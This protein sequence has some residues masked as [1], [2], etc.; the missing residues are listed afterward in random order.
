MSLGGG[1]DGG[2]A[3]DA[4]NQEEKRQR[5]I[6]AGTWLID[7]TFDKQ[8]DDPFYTGRR[9]GFLDYAMPQYGRQYKDAADELTYFLSRNGLLNSTVRSDKQQ[10]L[11]ELAGQRQR[12]IADQAL[13][14]EN[15]ARSAVEQSRANLVNTLN[16]SADAGQA[17]SSAIRQ[18]QVL[19]APPVYSPLGNLFVDFTSALGQQAAIERAAAYGGAAPLYNTGLFGPRGAVSVSR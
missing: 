3:E 11:A 2:A 14:Y 16:V 15:D 10:E 17:A 13:G 9:Q 12:E 1:G 4:R 19:S 18:A 7:N 6:R 5:R 8:F